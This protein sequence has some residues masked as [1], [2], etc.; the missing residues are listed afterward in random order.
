MKKPILVR[1]IPY[2]DET[3]ASILLRAT[4]LNGHANPAHL[5][6]HTGARQSFTSIVNNRVTFEKVSKALGLYLDT[7]AFIQYK[8]GL[9]TRSKRYFL[10]NKI[11]NMAFRPDATG[12]CHVCLN[13]QAYWRQLWLLRPYCVCHIHNELL[14]DHCPQCQTRLSASRGSITHCG[15]CDFDLRDCS[16][17]KANSH[18]T[19]WLIRILEEEPQS[20]LDKFF[21]FW[22]ACYAISE[23]QDM[24]SELIR[25]QACKDFVLEKKLAQKYIESFITSN[26][27]HPNPRIELLPLLKSQ[28]KEISELARAIISKIPRSIYENTKNHKKNLLNKLEASLVLGVSTERLPTHLQCI[29]AD[30]KRT[31]A[32]TSKG[33]YFST[34]EVLD[35]LYVPIPPKPIE[36]LSIKPSPGWRDITQAAKILLTNESCIR[37]L[38]NHNWLNA[39]K[40]KLANKRK[41]HIKKRSILNF[42]RKYILVGTL[43]KELG[44]TPNNLSE[45]LANVGIRPIGGP[46]IDGLLVSLFQRKDT[47]SL[48]KEYL[49]EIKEYATKTGRPI[50]GIAKE[51]LHD[52]DTIPLSDAARELKISVQKALTLVNKNILQKSERPFSHVLVKKSSLANLKH[53]LKRKDLISLDEASSILE[54]NKNYIK[55]NYISTGI[56]TLYDYH[57]WQFITRAH[58]KKLI[59]LNTGFVTA[60]EASKALNSHRSH[61]LNLAKQG[62]ISSTFYKKD[63]SIHLFDRE[64]FSELL[65]QL[66]ELVK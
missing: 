15:V 53:N 45:K 33:V 36:T 22:E 56:V 49:E 50:L 8:S 40:L 14:L 29:D 39:K 42:H 58:L 9:T 16:S 2:P 30:G 44:I 37:S 31:D 38:I 20:V 32:K 18:S 47:K 10:G 17:T 3:A 63:R 59:L 6:R 55:L 57:L 64:D 43:A 11:S 54:K 5:V 62:A 65:R 66:D 34:N 46:H 28:D 13:E 23:K 7:K 26:P 41:T 12:F 1:P 24:L 21:S 48:T 60:S 61:L 19:K 51:T 35:A 27:T 52:A 4:E 25:S